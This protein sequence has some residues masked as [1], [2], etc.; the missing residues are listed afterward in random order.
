MDS[1]L[2]GSPVYGIFQARILVWFAIF[3][4]RGSSWSRDWTQVSC[5]TG[6]FLLSEPTCK[7]KGIDLNVRKI[8]QVSSRLP[9]KTSVDSLLFIFLKINLFILIGGDLLYNIV[10]VFAIHW[11]ESAMGV[12]VSPSWT[13]HLPPHPI[14]QGH[15]SAPALSALSHALTWTGD[16]FHIW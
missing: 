1:S 12:H 8:E 7:L 6:R 10:V 9:L 15:P 4:S 3:F 16:L 11:R 14:P 2:P 5:T 13:P